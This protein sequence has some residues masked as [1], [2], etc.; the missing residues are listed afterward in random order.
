MRSKG[1]QRIQYGCWHCQ[2]QRGYPLRAFF[3]H[4]IYGG[5]ESSRCQKTKQ[6]YS[7]PGFIEVREQ[8]HQQYLGK[9]KIEELASSPARGSRDVWMWRRHGWYSLTSNDTLC[10]KTCSSR[11]VHRFHLLPLTMPRIPYLSC[12]ERSRAECRRSRRAVG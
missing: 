5:D 8:H 3:T 11:Y 2:G 4:R 12:L 9:K 1:E 7:Y 10:A 6:K